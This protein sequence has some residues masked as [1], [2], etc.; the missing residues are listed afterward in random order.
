MVTFGEYAKLRIRQL[1]K[2][3]KALAAE[4][5]VSPA[6]ISQI[7]NKKKNPPDLSRTKYRSALKTWCKFLESSE[8]D[9][10]DMVRF[11]LHRVPPRP[12]PK[13][14]GMRDLL[15]QSVKT[16]RK[17]LVEEMRAMS[18]HPAENRAIHA[19]VQ[20]YLVSQEQD[21]ESRACGATRFRNLC[22]RAKTNKKFVEGEL[23]DFFRVR[24]FS[25]TWDS[26]AD[27]VRLFSESNE[28]CRAIERVRSITDG[29]PGLTYARTVPVVGQV[30][31]GKGFEYTDG[32]FTLGEGFDQVEIPPGVDPVLAQTLYCVKVRGDSL[33][34]YF[35]DGALLFIKPES[36]EEIR[37]GDL[38]IFK[39]RKGGRAFVKKVE[40]AGDNLILKSMNPLY[41]NI[42]LGRT[43]LMFLERVMALRF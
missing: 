19:L 22:I 4:L 5:D 23:T 31:A 9:I 18:L 26:E 20:I 16:Q 35:G 7:I 40:F 15:I 27:D 14:R 8:D 38:V 3:Q 6:Y 10:L 32:G 39:D 29:T 17:D 24:P 43:D 41:K 13:F 1:G 11:E 42:V 25:W 30:S 2:S 28:I 36:W 21:G 33:R 34:E 37:D 12:N